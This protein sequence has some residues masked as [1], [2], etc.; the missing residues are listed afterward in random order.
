V[1][2]ESLLFRWRKAVADSD[3]PASR[4]LVAFT[5]SLHMNGDGG[6]CYPS[7]DLQA[8]ES[9]LTR[10]TVTQSLAHL[11]R[12]EWIYRT[13][14]KGGRSKGGHGR[15]THYRIRFPAE[16]LNKQP[17]NEHPVNE[18]QRTVKSTPK[19]RLPINHKDGFRASGGRAAKRR[20]D[21]TPSPYATS[22]RECGTSKR[23]II[24]GL[25]SDCRSAA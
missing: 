15:S 4:K 5:L 6:S 19:N 12:D 20:N 18:S 7:L 22:C 24:D 8:E 1:A 16:L 9:S 10:A 14:S 11:E 3:L 13:R 23:S 25:C 17:V 21:E 2:S